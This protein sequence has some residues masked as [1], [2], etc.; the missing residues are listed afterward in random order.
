MVREGLSVELRVSI[1]PQNWGGGGVCVSVRCGGLSQVRHSPQGRRDQG[2][3]AR[4][5]WGMLDEVSALY[6]YRGNNPSF[7]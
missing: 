3:R 5:E 1:T 2:L 4:A 7:Q 6:L